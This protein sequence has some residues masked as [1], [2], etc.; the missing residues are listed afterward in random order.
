MGY[1]PGSFTDRKHGELHWEA[2]S[3]HIFRLYNH[4]ELESVLILDLE[5][6]RKC[7]NDLQLL[8]CMAEEDSL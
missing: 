3:S 4:N 7:A 6:A 2:G 5:E 8:V 1:S